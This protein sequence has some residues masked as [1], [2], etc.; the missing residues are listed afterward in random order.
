MECYR[1][2]SIAFSA[3][4]TGMKLRSYD[5]KWLWVIGFV[6]R[7]QLML[8]L[9]LVSFSQPLV[10]LA[11]GF[12]LRQKKDRISHFSES[13]VQVTKLCGGCSYYD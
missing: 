2:E 5:N 4:E 9:V 11:S 13:K 7:S 8:L 12:L 1:T 6:T 10:V 3:S